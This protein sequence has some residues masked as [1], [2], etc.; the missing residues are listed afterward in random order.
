MATPPPSPHPTPH[1]TAHPTRSGSARGNP[2]AAPSSAASAPASPASTTL[3][4]ETID[5][6][7]HALAAE[8]AAVWTCGLATAFLAQSLAP[9]LTEAETTHR[10][11]RDATGRLLSDA[12]ATPFPAEP[13]YLPPQPVTDQPSALAL[14]AT[15]E[16]DAAAAW[17]A[18]LERTDDAE[19]RRTAGEALTNAAVR[20]TR[21]RKAAGTRPATTPFPGQS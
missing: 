20:T 11:R 9:A 10:A 6:L 8:H 4:N 5:A 14:L 18:V 2:V 3:S 7:Q 17:R 12:G 21:W 19:L 1:P 13:A 15:A 16:T